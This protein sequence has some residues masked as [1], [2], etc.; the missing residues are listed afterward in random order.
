MPGYELIGK[1]EQEAVQ[2]IFEEG[3]ILFAHGFDA[4]R[5]SYNVREFE[6]ACTKFSEV[7]IIPARNGTSIFK[8]R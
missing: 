5:K 3:G 6:N 7:G 2:K 4:I 1:E 8:L